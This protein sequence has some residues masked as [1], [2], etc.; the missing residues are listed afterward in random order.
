MPAHKLPPFA[1]Y[2]QRGNPLA[3]R[4]LHA[5]INWQKG[6]RFDP[7]AD[8]F[9]SRDYRTNRVGLVPTGSSLLYQPTPFGRAIRNSVGGTQICRWNDAN[10]EYDSSRGVTFFVCA[11]PLSIDQP[12]VAVL[13]SKRDTSS[14]TAGGW[15][16][17]T[18]SAPSPDTYFGTVTN[19]AVSA[20]VTSTT[21]LSLTRTDVVVVR[22]DPERAQLSI[23]VNGV[24][25]NTVALGFAPT[26]NA[27]AVRMFNTYEG[28]INCVAAWNRPLSD[29]E[30]R[31]L[32]LDPYRLWRPVPYRY[33]EGLA[34]AIA[35]MADNNDCCRCPEWMTGPMA[36]LS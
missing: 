7:G 25:E 35:D 18:T 17:Q 10:N 13:Y 16:L 34:A 4:L 15:E 26:N 8:D 1:P 27:I 22:A 29:S 30:I 28:F 19:G 6:F 24:K 3:K 20:D 12:G 23:W 36:A 9:I 14:A 33:G 32:Y 11:K 31:L 2:L 21:G 5:V